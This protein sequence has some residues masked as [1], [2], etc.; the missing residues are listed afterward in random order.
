[1]NDRNN[2]KKRIEEED[3]ILAGSAEAAAGAAGAAAAEAAAAGDYGRVPPWAWWMSAKR[4]KTS[5]WQMLGYI[6]LVFLL[7]ALITPLTAG[8]F[9]GGAIGSLLGLG[10]IILAI[11]KL[12]DVVQRR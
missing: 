7:L 12:V 2:R 4:R 8:V 1:M 10:I 5:G 3:E 9:A 6:V 11:W